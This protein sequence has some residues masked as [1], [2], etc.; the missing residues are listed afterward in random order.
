MRVARPHLAPSLK[1]TVQKLTQSRVALT[2]TIAG[3]LLAVATVTFGYSSLTT[4]VT[5]AVDGQ[6]RSVTTFGDTVQDVLDAEGIELSSRDLVQPGVDETIE[7]G[8]RISVR[9]SRPIELT[10]DGKTSTHWVTATDVQGALAQI[11]VVY[12]DSRLSTSRGADIDRGGAEIDVVTPKKL[13]FKLAG[14]KAITRTVPALTVED[15]LAEVGVELDAQDKVRPARSAKVE[16]GDTIVFTDIETRR[17]SVEDE[18][19]PAPVRRIEDDSMYEGE[20]KVVTEGVDGVRDVTYRVI[21]R[22]GDVVRRIVLTQDVSKAPRAEIV[23]V[24]TKTVTANFAGGNTVW[25]RL[26]QCESGGNWA[27]NT[28]NGYYGGLQFNVGTWRAYGG[29]GYPHQASR[30]TQIAIAT[31]VRD[32]SG[33]YGAWPGCAASL[34]LPR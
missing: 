30:E 7:A 11:G 17:R 18:V 34:G 33:G 10:V 26:A 12:A 14:K 1:G 9:Y 5:L 31:K 27:I 19:V 23:H 8:D 13:V 15:A 2:A 24:G 6:E 32:A 16:D 29:S 20:S 25:D 21:V 22:N 3:V 4:E 28:G